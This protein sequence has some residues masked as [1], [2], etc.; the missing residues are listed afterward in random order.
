MILAEA[1][2][3]KS[4]DVQSSSLACALVNRDSKLKLEL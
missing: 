2:A 1:A 3:L 4:G